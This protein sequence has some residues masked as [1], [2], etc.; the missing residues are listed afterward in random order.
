MVYDLKSKTPPTPTYL[1]HKNDQKEYRTPNIAKLYLKSSID[2]LPI[3]LTIERRGKITQERWITLKKFKDEV[4]K[5]S[6]ED[7]GNINYQLTFIH[8]NRAFHIE[9]TLIVPWNDKLKIEFITFRDKLKPNENEEWRVKISG[10]NRE[11]VVAEMVAT[12]YDASLD[13]FLP[14]QFS[15]PNL[16]PIF[17]GN[18]RTHWQ[19]KNFKIISQEHQWRKYQ[20]EQ[21]QRLFSYLKWSNFMNYNGGG[22]EEQLL[23]QQQCQ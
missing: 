13:Q 9:D 16:F 14:H 23:Y 20:K 21:L 8:N 6:K 12:M 11:K 1:W 17:R 4:I 19:E 22:M 10:E 2:E 7:R 5:I 3:L 15:I 18:Y